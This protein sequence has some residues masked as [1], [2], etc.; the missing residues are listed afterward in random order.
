MA[1]EESYPYINI[2]AQW[3]ALDIPPI[4]TAGAITREFSLVKDASSLGGCCC[5]CEESS[6]MLSLDVDT[7]DAFDS[8]LEIDGFPDEDTGAALSF[9]LLPAR[10]AVLGAVARVSLLPDR[11][12]REVDLA[13]DA[14]A[15]EVGPADFVVA[16]SFSLE[17]MV[18]SFSLELFTLSSL[19]VALTSSLDTFLGGGGV[20]EGSEVAMASSG[21]ELT[22]EPAI[23][24]PVIL[25]TAL[26]VST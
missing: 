3:H 2:D 8:L 15:V 26:E 4:S 12:D 17:G 1:D 7:L 5:C 13:L 25:W 19:T 23:G 16:V 6:G 21:R 11:S 22:E 24:L 9:S 14:V 18:V 20:S 10:A